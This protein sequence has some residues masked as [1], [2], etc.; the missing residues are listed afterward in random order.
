VLILERN[1]GIQSFQIT[2]VASGVLRGI[3]VW[4]LMAEAVGQDGIR[5]VSGRSLGSVVKV[6]VVKDRVLPAG[7]AVTVARRELF[8][9][10]DEP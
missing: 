9:E 2:P 10:G 7:R 3:A 6:G 4:R 5:G 8:A 1:G